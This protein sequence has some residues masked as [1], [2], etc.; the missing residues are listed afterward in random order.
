MA[1]ST[2]KTIKRVLKWKAQLD[3]V[4]WVVIPVVFAL[5]AISVALKLPAGIIVVTYLATLAAFVYS[6]FDNGYRGLTKKTISL[7]GIVIR[8]QYAQLLGF[9]YIVFGFV[10]LSASFFGVI[11]FTLHLLTSN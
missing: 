8:G 2:K 4:M 7:K 9:I 11:G 5:F 1:H 6:F 3:R 10:L